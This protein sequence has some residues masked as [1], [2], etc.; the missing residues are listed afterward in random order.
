MRQLPR[1]VAAGLVLI[2]ALL[3]VP[4]RALPRVVLHFP[5]IT[6][7]GAGKAFGEPFSGLADYHGDGTTNAG[8]YTIMSA[9]DE[10]V[11]EFV[12]AASGAAPFYQSQTV[13]AA[14][15]IGLAAL[16]AM[17]AVAGA[18]VIFRKPRP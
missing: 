1:T 2:G 16:G 6:V 5:A 13:P 8:V 14:V 15:T 7:Y 12:K 10:G 9:R 11:A 17:I 3:A 18:F 4:A